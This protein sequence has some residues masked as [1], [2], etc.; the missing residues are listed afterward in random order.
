MQ[1]D[2][3]YNTTIEKQKPESSCAVLQHLC[4]RIE[5]LASYNATAVMQKSDLSGLD[6]QLPARKRTL[7]SKPANEHPSHAHNW[8]PVG[9]AE[10][11]VSCMTVLQMYNAGERR[12]NCKPLGLCGK[13]LLII[14]IT[15]LLKGRGL[16][17]CALYFNTCENC[18]P[19]TL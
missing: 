18:N 15:Q 8:Y 1:A 7:T 10:Q 19:C 6:V 14:I 3:D 9:Y 12:L 2:V 17:P 16:N 5:A 4:G 11:L 13:P